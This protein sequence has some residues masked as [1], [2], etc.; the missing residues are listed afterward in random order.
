M[1]TA[2]A[3][4]GKTATKYTFAVGRR[5]AATASVKLF[6]NGSGKFTIIKGEKQT[7]LKEYFLGH[8]HLIYEMLLP[9]T[10]LGADIVNKFDAEIRVTSGGKAG[11]ADSIKLGFA[12]ALVEY[13]P[14]VRP[15]L[16]PHELLKRDP[17]KK[18]R[19]K[20]GLKKARKAPKWSKR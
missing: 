10:V 16:K 20:P 11:Q 2:K 17:R 1:A 18:E 9:F 15:Q 7:P 12:R 13:N 3:T 4:A 14:E 6:P 8:D 19:K 5:K